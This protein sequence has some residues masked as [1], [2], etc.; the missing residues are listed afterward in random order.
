MQARR[1]LWTDPEQRFDR[2]RIQ[3][4]AHISGPDFTQAIRF[5]QVR[6]NF[7]DQFVRPDPD[8]RG[9]PGV[10]QDSLLDAPGNLDGLS[11]RRNPLTDVQERLVQRQ[12]FDDRRDLP[13]D[14]EN[15][16]G[17]FLIAGNPR[18]D[19]R[20]VRAKL[21]RAAHRHCRVDAVFS[22][23]ITGCRDYAAGPG[24]AHQ[25]GFVLEFRVI[26]FFHRR[27]KGIH[28]DMQHMP[29]SFDLRATNHRPS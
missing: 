29:L 15:Y 10:R 28:V 5:F 12:A 23:F 16:R 17:N 8:G 13:E 21:Q 4:C 19:D 26:A 6:R 18:L 2:Q 7:G 27:I 22:R 25:D 9:Q 11:V 1:G 14:R 3:H 20:G 24:A